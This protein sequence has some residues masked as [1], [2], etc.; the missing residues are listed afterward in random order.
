LALTPLALRVDICSISNGGGSGFEASFLSSYEQLNGLAGNP[1]S[2]SFSLLR[3][4][5]ALMM[6]AAR[7]AV[8]NNLAAD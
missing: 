8:L 6:R 1:S 4:V 5:A 2:A 3:L 7:T